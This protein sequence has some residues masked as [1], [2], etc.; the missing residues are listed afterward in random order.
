MNINEVQIGDKFQDEDT[1][2]WTVTK[3]QG[4]NWEYWIELE[5]EGGQ[6]A[7]FPDDFDDGDFF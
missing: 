3:V 2:I 6:V 1:D 7:S 4:N 5:T